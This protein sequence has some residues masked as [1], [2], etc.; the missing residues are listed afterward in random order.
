[1][2]LGIIYYFCG[3]AAATPPFHG[4]KRRPE[5]TEHSSVRSR[6]F[7]SVSTLA[8]ALLLYR[9]ELPLVSRQLLLLAISTAI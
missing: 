4:T 1:M 9:M 8:L 7:L 3:P 6:D 2:N 5:T